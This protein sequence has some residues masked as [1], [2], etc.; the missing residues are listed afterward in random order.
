MSKNETTAAR[1]STVQ[2][3]AAATVQPLVGA[4]ETTGTTI[5]VTGHKRA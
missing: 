1:R 2:T 5:L 3:H 4:L